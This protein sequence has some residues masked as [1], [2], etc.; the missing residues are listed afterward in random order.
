[1]GFR[2]F[3]VFR[4]LLLGV[5][6]F[7]CGWGMSEMEFPEN[8]PLIFINST[9]SRKISARAILAK[10]WF[11]AIRQGSKSAPSGAGKLWD[12]EWRVAGRFRIII[13]FRTLMKISCSGHPFPL[14]GPKSELATPCDKLAT[15]CDTRNLEVKS[16]TASWSK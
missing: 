2:S 11:W 8:L 14:S 12:C 10:T 3:R 9:T 16:Q 4:R 7:G 15:P 6:R 13:D 5:V 1:M